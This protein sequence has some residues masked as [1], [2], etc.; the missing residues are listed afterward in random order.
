[1]EK[2]YVKN[3]KTNKTVEEF[4]LDIIITGKYGGIR[5]YKT[6]KDKY[7]KK[8][9]YQRPYRSFYTLYCI[10]KTYYG[11]L[12]L[13]TFAKIIRKY[14]ENEEKAHLLFCPTAS[15]IIVYTSTGGISGKKHLDII[16]DYKEGFKKGHG[17]DDNLPLKL[18]D[19]LTLMDY[20]E[21]EINSVYL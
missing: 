6:K 4:L 19:I 14:L 11:N 18:K 1:M 12:T 10:C 5:T 9:Y 13:K 20:S 3:K 8:N 7:N 21:E 15:N 17:D 2:L 16:L